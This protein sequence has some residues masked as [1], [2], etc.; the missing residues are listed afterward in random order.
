MTQTKYDFNRWLLKKKTGS[1]TTALCWMWWSELVHIYLCE[2]K[3]EKWIQMSEICTDTVWQEGS[4]RTTATIRQQAAA[5]DLV[6]LNISYSASLFS[7]SFILCMQYMKNVSHI[8]YIFQTLLNAVCICNLADATFELKDM[9][10]DKSIKKATGWT[11]Y[12]EKLNML[13]PKLL[14]FVRYRRPS[15]EG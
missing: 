10:K 5:V 3:H 7:L 11:L 14:R 1:K 8:A 9:I 2:P 4:Q 6:L 12:K 15:K 13:Y